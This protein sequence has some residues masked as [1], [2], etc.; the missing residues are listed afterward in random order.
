MTKLDRLAEEYAYPI[1][2]GNQI[3]AFKAGYRARDEEVKEL[4]NCLEIVRDGIIETAQDTVWVGVS[5][6]AV[7]YIDLILC[8]YKTGAIKDE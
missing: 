2:L 6:T 1:P 7:D 4:I 8:E 3:E 5:S